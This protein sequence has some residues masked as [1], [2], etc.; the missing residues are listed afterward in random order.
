MSLST[1]SKRNILL[2]AD[3]CCECGDEAHINHPDGRIFCG[4]KLKSK[5]YFKAIKPLAMFE[6]DYI[7]ICP[8]CHSENRSLRNQ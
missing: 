7:V 4:K 3:Y 6:D 8:S 2:R 1:Q 5:Y